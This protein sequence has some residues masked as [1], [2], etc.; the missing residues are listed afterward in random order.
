MKIPPAIHIYTDSSKSPHSNEIGIAYVVVN[1]KKEKIIFEFNKKLSNYTNNQGELLAI[2]YATLFILK[3]K[4]QFAV[5]ATD[6]QYAVNILNNYFQPKKNLKI[7]NKIFDILKECE[8]HTLVK[9]V[10]VK[11]HNGNKFNERADFLANVARNKKYKLK[12]KFH[13]Q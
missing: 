2:L 1:P 7:I 13:N 8:K 10:W 9:I 11:A 12:K 5:I 4:P 3:Y 6:S